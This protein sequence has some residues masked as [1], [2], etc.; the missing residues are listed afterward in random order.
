MST[1]RLRWTYPV[2]ALLM[3][4]AVTFSCFTLFAR[5]ED[6]DP[7]NG[8]SGVEQGEDT[9]PGASDY[10]VTFDNPYDDPDVREFTEEMTGEE[11]AWMFKVTYEKDG[12]TLGLSSGDTVPSGT[13]VTVKAQYFPAAGTVYANRLESDGAPALGASGE[14][15]QTPLFT[16]ES[17]AIDWDS[18]QNTVARGEGT[19][20]VDSDVKLEYKVGISTLATIGNIAFPGV[21][22]AYAEYTV[23]N[24]GTPA[25]WTHYFRCRN[26]S[27]NAT[28]N[29]SFTAPT[30]AQI[31][32]IL[33]TDNEYGHY[34]VSTIPLSS[35]PTTNNSSSATCTHDWRGWASFILT[36]T[37]G[38]NISLSTTDLTNLTTRPFNVTTTGTVTLPAS[39][40]L[41]STN[42]QVN[43][44][45]GGVTLGNGLAIASGASLTTAAGKTVTLNGNITVAAGASLTI[46]GTL[47]C[48]GHTITNNGTVTLSGNTHTNVNINGGMVTR[49]GALSAGSITL[50]NVTANA[51]TSMSSSGNITLSNSSFSVLQSITSS[52][53]S[54]SLSSVTGAGT[55]NTTLTSITT[56]STGT[57]ITITSTNCSALTTLT[58]PTTTPRHITINGSSIVSVTNQVTTYNF[59]LAG[60]ASA[61]LA[62]GIQVQNN[63]SINTTNTAT[64]L[65]CGTSNAL[66]RN[67]IT[68]AQGRLNANVVD[69]AHNTFGD[70]ANST[71]VAHAAI[72]TMHGRT[73]VYPNAGT[74]AITM[75]YSM[76]QA[77][78]GGANYTYTNLY[79]GGAGSTSTCPSGAHLNHTPQSATIN[80]SAGTMVTSFYGGS[81]AHAMS[82]NVTLNI[83][84]A[85]NGA[86][87]SQTALFGGGL[88]NNVG[89]VTI[90]IGPNRMN[91]TGTGTAANTS[92][93]GGGHASAAS[94]TANVTSTSV[95]VIGANIPNGYAVGGGYAPAA[96]STANVTN[97]SISLTGTTVGR[98]VY[99][100][101]WADGANS[102]AQVT[103]GSA[104]AIVAFSTVN[105]GYVVG[106][107]RASGA[108]A[109][110]NV[111]G[112]SSASVTSTP[113]GN[114]VYGGGWADG[115]GSTATVNGGSTATVDASAITGYVVGGGHSPTNSTA[116]VT[117]DSAA[118]VISGATVGQNVYGGGWASGTSNS[119]AN[120]TSG[121]SFATITSSA[122][123]GSYGVF[124]GGA[125]T[126]TGASATV[127]G[128]AGVNATGSNTVRNSIHGGGLSTS[129]GNANV[130][131][132]AGTR[133]TV[134]GGTINSASSA[135]TGVFGGGRSTGT[136]TSTAT[137]T[138]PA[139]VT[140]DGNAT[141]DGLVHG[142]GYATGG[143]ADVNGKAIVTIDS[144]A[145]IATNGGLEGSVYGGGRA[146]GGSADVLA[147]TEVILDGAATLVQGSVYG[148]GRALA[149]NT[150]VRQ[151]TKVE[152][153][154]GIVG[155]AG[156]PGTFNGSIYGGG[157]ANG[158]WTADVTQDTDVLMTGGHVLNQVFGGGYN[159]K[160]G[161]NTTT[162]VKGDATVEY[163][164]F[165]GGWQDSTS[166][167]A[168]VD[169]YTT[170]Y[171]LRSAH[172]CKMNGNVYG[173]G[174]NN[175][176]IR[177]KNAGN[178][179]TTVNISGNVGTV[180]NGQ[181]NGNVYG[182]GYNMQILHD[183]SVNLL[184]GSDYTITSSVYG[185]GW[186]PLTY[187]QGV[188]RI[189]IA[190]GNVLGSV[191]GG[192]RDSSDVK[193]NDVLAGTRTFAT[194][195]LMTNGYVEHDIYGGG[196][197][198]TTPG[199]T[200]TI[201]G[202]TWMNLTG[203]KVDDSVY[204]G[205]LNANVL[206]RTE[207]YQSGTHEITNDAW[208]GGHFITA[209]VPAAGRMAKI[210][211]NTIVHIDAKVGRNV[212]GGGYRTDV[213]K[214]AYVFVKG[215]GKVGRDVFGGGKENGD[216]DDKTQVIVDGQ[217]ERRVYGGGEQGIVHRTSDVKINQTAIVGERVFGGGWDIAFKPYS[218]TPP[219][220]DNFV[221]KA[222]TVTIDGTVGRGRAVDGVYGG[223]WSTDVSTTSNDGVKVLVNQTGKVDGSVYGG[224][225]D[226]AIVY[227]Y[228]GTVVDIYGTVTK[229]VHGGG[230]NL[231]HL[232]H[233]T[234][235]GTRVTIHESGD[236]HVDVF[237]GGRESDVFSEDAAN[238][239]IK[240]KVG[241]H[242]QLPDM[243]G[244]SVYGGGYNGYV[245]IAGNKGPNVHV[246]GN[247][248][249][250]YNNVYGGGWYEGR[251]SRVY[252][253]T[254]LVD[255]SANVQ[256]AVFGGGRNGDNYR[257]TTGAQVLTTT[258]VL[259]KDR[260]TILGIPEIV[261]LYLNQEKGNEDIK[262]PNERFYNRTG[263][264]FDK[265][266]SVY[267]GGS[268]AGVVDN[269]NVRIENLKQLGFNRISGGNIGLASDNSKQRVVTLTNLGTSVEPDDG[270]WSM[271]YDKLKYYGAIRFLQDYTVSN[272]YDSF[273]TVYYNI[274]ALDDGST[275]NGANYNPQNYAAVYNFHRGTYNPWRP[276]EHTNV[277]VE[278][279]VVLHD[280]PNFRVEGGY[281]IYMYNEITLNPR[282]VRVPLLI[283]YILDKGCTTKIHAPKDNVTVDYP[284]HY[285]YLPE[286]TTEVDLYDVG[287]ARVTGISVY[288]PP[289]NIE[290]LPGSPTSP[291]GSTG[292]DG[293]TGISSGGG[294]GGGGR[295][296]GGGGTGAAVTGTTIYTDVTTG[297]AA[298]L[299]EK[300]AGAASSSG[301][302]YGTVNL[303]NAGN[304]S[305]DAMKAM[306]E[307]AGKTPLRVYA[308]SYNLNNTVDVR[309]IF[310][311][312]KATKSINLQGST[313]SA[314]A[315][316]LKAA[317]EKWYQNKTAIIALEQ[318]GDF[319]MEVEIA[320]KVDLSGMDTKDLCF[321]SHD[322][323]TNAYKRIAAPKY[324]IDKNGYLRFSTV[325]AGDIVV[326]EGPLIR[327]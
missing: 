66:A 215:N 251:D 229:S 109:N 97:S 17:G 257:G 15:L 81:H 314:G 267:G 324:W 235:R 124:G 119:V 197:D 176:Q 27:T 240:G 7:P 4:L 36:Y 252:V 270:F 115:A 30:V 46:N 237:G 139:T 95:T 226:G 275:I 161:R 230:Q 248:A 165:G 142:G 255:N 74:G 48:N 219:S 51:I 301:M 110:A 14:E 236:V 264:I 186:S 111:S 224:G 93:F 6:G 118:N 71:Y 233:N 325:L 281:T 216:I 272:V 290:W 232:A 24:G 182:A 242:F 220:N 132:A 11:L 84:P 187:V 156:S 179:S 291:G 138:G 135:D 68:V 158:S 200:S 309:I 28:A 78:L 304:M 318:Q 299:G 278:P 286:T 53:G 303:K 268:Y 315:Q 202:N 3:A 302:G 175:S 319:G 168:D 10:K 221:E 16:L 75:L 307:A 250:C 198:N 214:D 185:G 205:G 39:G 131:G 5:G 287:D 193:N 149:S 285:D 13:V 54:I 140:V 210:R 167:N 23:S 296:G 106:G 49:S 166:N 196:W 289:T 44:A 107:G 32:S 157:S 295:S 276:K 64:G 122:V 113:V 19:Y 77:D 203:G 61:T 127:S 212:Y 284:F 279:Y 117:G 269:T 180:V 60:S 260:D 57:S 82:G 143:S 326:S 2:V 101:G 105:N 58:T 192:G 184:A 305:L 85:S 65:N 126:D 150:Q 211:D 249:V 209:S 103:N 52:G 218:Q 164:V 273:V 29:V 25:T 34:C 79:G 121:N 1:R 178:F 245:R 206:G 144:G 265:C 20:T 277:R 266:G 87:V 35:N 253:T 201:R 146:N 263:N 136:A 38:E 177:N 153:K 50:A 128:T 40:T 162:T 42:F 312:A 8:L 194:E 130:L 256:G 243:T 92:L 171:V 147:D 170:V 320:A 258:D 43:G 199:N 22:N 145:Q 191:F 159:A 108:P 246:T 141:V 259:V 225:L 306:I 238:V 172:V 173:G 137:V 327:K 47:D 244:G 102:S 280:S 274:M 300:A 114:N 189:N 311:P 163:D 41:S 298:E 90:N 282:S 228:E 55:S 152:M 227:G 310:D 37:G 308:D 96:S 18:D 195:I 99:G 239:L 313:V 323:K 76:G 292:T 188:T 217:V 208:G 133:V 204:G 234:K 181:L 283:D 231:S 174:Y 26:T 89:T 83:S 21:R 94:S 80:M 116:T 190:G 213:E 100:G 120:V 247:E 112:G 317:Y 322:R 241:H 261:A 72:T 154:N 321:Y 262:S 63:I 222:V 316:A 129:I 31:P 69:S 59:N 123:N 98:D 91:F 151:D 125:A 88:N 9:Q 293:G 288:I 183:T 294:G 73:T 70:A 160:I 62:N 56:T 155:T 33:D 254:V 104:T 86:V 148:G 223:G 67:T 134:T 297:Q 207:V 12:A 45:S 271:P 169:G